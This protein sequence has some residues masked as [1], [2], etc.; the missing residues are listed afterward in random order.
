MERKER[1]EIPFFLRNVSILTGLRMLTNLTKILGR[2][3]F[4]DFKQFKF[5]EKVEILKQV[6]SIILE[7][8]H[9]VF[10]FSNRC[11]NFGKLKPLRFLELD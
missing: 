4:K 11:P 6:I 2:N 7:D 8:V 9:D 3:C 10:L 5:D 1:I